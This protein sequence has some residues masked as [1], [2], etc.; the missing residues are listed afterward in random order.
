MTHDRPR[1][2]LHPLPPSQRT[3]P[4][5]PS[6]SHPDE[7]PPKEQRPHTANPFSLPSPVTSRPG[8]RLILRWPT[9]LVFASHGAANITQVIQDALHGQQE[10]IAGVNWTKRQSLAIHAAAPFSAAALQVRSSMFIPGLR[11]LF[12]ADCDPVV[13]LDTPWTGVLLRNVP[14]DALRNALA[15]G[16][17]TVPREIARQ[18]NVLM[19]EIKDVRVLCNADEL[20]SKDSLSVRIMISSE[21]TAAQLLREGTFLVS[22]F[23]RTAP[24]R[25]R[26]T[27]RPQ[28]TS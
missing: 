8:S 1:Q 26:S 6:A 9:P 22:A 2:L 28:K 18:N 19:E 14:G 13:E 15:N 4:R 20:R 23:C 21:R 12:G 10:R 5:E 24:Y 11:A 27:P 3:S 7:A 16:T 25:R 17:D